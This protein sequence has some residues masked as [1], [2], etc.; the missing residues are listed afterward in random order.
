M[1]YVLG[2]YAREVKDNFI[3]LTKEKGPLWPLFYYEKYSYYDQKLS[4][5]SFKSVDDTT[6]V[7]CCYVLL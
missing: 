7:Y 5:K 3:K 1:S 2:T 4:F 6:T